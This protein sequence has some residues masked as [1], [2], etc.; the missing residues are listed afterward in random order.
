M[1]DVPDEMLQALSLGPDE[2]VLDTWHAWLWE[3]IYLHH[4]FRSQS[5]ESQFHE[6]FLV[7]TNERLVFLK[8]DLIEP[9][10]EVM[11]KL[12]LNPNEIT[13]MEVS[14]ED[15]SV[16]KW[17][18]RMKHTNIG[19]IASTIKQAMA[20]NGGQAITQA[21]GAVTPQ[22]GPGNVPGSAGDMTAGGATAG[23]I[24]SDDNVQMTSCPECHELTPSDK[25][26]CA[27]CGA[28]LSWMQ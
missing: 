19:E 23:A 20:R 6:G 2:D 13:D 28:D 26:K 14:S 21:P 11:V 16:D 4:G 22:P 8:K 17:N 7:L 3:R 12:G 9:R 10:F 18:F 27:N 24:S 5:V 15:L 25:N 1:A